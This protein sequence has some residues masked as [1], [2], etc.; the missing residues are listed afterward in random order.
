MIKLPVFTVRLKTD[1][2]A[3]STRN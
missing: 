3:L 1:K 2:R